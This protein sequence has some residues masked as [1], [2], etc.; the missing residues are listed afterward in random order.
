MRA[1]PV[2][3]QRLEL[4]HRHGVPLEVRLR[5]RDRAEPTPM[6]STVCTIDLGELASIPADVPRRAHNDGGDVLLDP[7]LFAERA[8]RALARKDR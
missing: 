4:V 5:D 1:G 7:E 2:L 6:G 8:A 3:V